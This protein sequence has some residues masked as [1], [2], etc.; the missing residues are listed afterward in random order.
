MIKSLLINNLL[1]ALLQIEVDDK[2]KK[3]IQKKAETYGITT[4]AIIRII[5][6]KSFGNPEQENLKAG[7]VFNADRDNNGKALKLDDLIN[8][9]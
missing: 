8:A 9:L 2:L 6:V 5:L 3:A 7:N 4:S 1:M